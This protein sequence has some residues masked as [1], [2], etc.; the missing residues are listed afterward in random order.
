[1]KAVKSE[2][3][4]P[5]AKFLKPSP[6]TKK[7]LYFNDVTQ[8]I[9]ESAYTSKQ[10]QFSTYL[11]GQRLFRWDTKQ[12]IEKFEA[13]VNCY[14]QCVIPKENIRFH[15]YHKLSG[16]AT[17]KDLSLARRAYNHISTT[18]L[19]IDT[20]LLKVQNRKQDLYNAQLELKKW[21]TNEH[22]VVTEFIAK[23]TAMKGTVE[24][25][26]DY[27]GQT[28][29]LLEKRYGKRSEDDY[30]RKRKQ[31]RQKEQRSKNK[32][33]IAVLNKCRRE[34]LEKKKAEPDSDS[35]YSSEHSDIDFDL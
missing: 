31:K 29:K 6:K 22:D 24:K 12:N 21:A 32:R 19:A 34:M 13:I 2:D 7:M 3:V 14:V 33:K 35:S 11:N 28:V 5:W 26:E 9:Y 18:K 17:L 30:E 15:N 1:M 16:D 10:T 27:I 25:I 8:Q 4:K 20:L 23:A